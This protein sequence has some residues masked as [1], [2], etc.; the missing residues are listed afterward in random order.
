MTRTSRLPGWLVPA[1]LAGLAALIL[2]LSPAEQ[3]LGANVRIVYLH[4]SLTRAGE[5]GLALA[6]LVGLGL[7]INPSPRLDGWAA[8]ISR[9]GLGFYAAGFAVSM[10]AEQVIWGGISLQEP[11]MIAALNVLAVAAIVQV[12][13]VWLP[14]RRVRAALHVVMAAVVIW[15]LVTAQNVLHPGAA[16][17]SSN[18]TAIKLY[19]YA[20]LVVCLLAAGWIAWRVRQPARLNGWLPGSE[21]AG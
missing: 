1:G 6:G 19:S 21:P 8:S 7:L 14:Q 10:V 15:A 5:I 18:S 13:I 2:V 17:G 16:I 11:R 4:V 12:L 3:T 9:V 20:F